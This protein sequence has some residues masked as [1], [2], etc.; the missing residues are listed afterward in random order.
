LTGSS[1]DAWNEEVTGR[2]KI[3]EEEEEREKEKAKK[4]PM[5]EE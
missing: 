4:R 3:E 5:R 1:F 2:E